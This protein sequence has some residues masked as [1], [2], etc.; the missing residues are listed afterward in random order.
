MKS[1][2]FTTAGF[3][4]T[5]QSDDGI[6]LAV[7]NGYIP[8]VLPEFSGKSDLSIKVE[9][10]IPKGMDLENEVLFK[11]CNDTQ[12]FYSI[13][14]HEDQYKFIVYDQNCDNRIQQVALL[15]KDLSTWTIYTIPDEEGKAYPLR[16]PMGPL[17]LYYLTVKF[18]AIMMH[19]SGI[20]EESGGRIFSGF[21]GVGK[22]TMA[23]I[24]QHSGCKV[25]NDDR[26]IIRK[27]NEDYVVHNTPMFYPD[28]P[29]KTRL[30]AV[31]L[32]YHSPENTI[33]KINGA[34][35]VSKVMAYCIQN[36]F[37]TKFIEHHLEFLSEMC[38][39]IPVYN[40]GFKPDPSIVD[41]IK[42]YA[43]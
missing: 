16:Y 6:D 41:Y 3:I 34:L 10:S 28:I 43:D 31:H 42:S 17:V 4:I 24:W 15:N 9:D 20:E 19:A 27:E 18:D 38:N 14:Q 22:S 36:S 37:N 11:A 30:K 25:I 12:N 26:L 1:L 2:T 40:V 7:E 29:K 13:S 35:A 21:S 8:F 5:L 32:I 23:A 33:R 39:K